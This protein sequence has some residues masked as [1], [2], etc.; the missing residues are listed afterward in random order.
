MADLTNIA[1]T[2]IPAPARLPALGAPELSVEY[3]AK[4]KEILEVLL[5]RRGASDWDRAVTFRDLPAASVATD[6]EAALR[7]STAYRSLVRKISD[8]EQMASYP[9]EIRAQLERALSDLARDR[10]ADI[11]TVENK[12]Q[13]ATL[14]MASRLQEI[15]AALDN[16]DAGVREFSAAYADSLRTVALRIEQLSASG[17]NGTA[18]L[19]ERLEAISDEVDG[20]QANY[21]LK[22]Q[23]NPVNGQ[24]P[25]I[26]GIDLSATSPVAG[27][28]TSALIF[29]AEAFKFLTQ[30]GSKQLVTISGDE[31]NLNANVT[32]RN[33]KVGAPD[34]LIQDPQFKDLIYW[35][36]VGCAVGDWAAYSG[37]TPWKGGASLYLG[38][39]TGAK[40]ESNTPYFNIEPGATYRLDFQISVPT[41]FNGS[42][43]V[44]LLLP[45]SYWWPMCGTVNRRGTWPSDGRGIDFG[46]AD[47]GQLLSFSTLL[48]VPNDSRNSRALIG[49]LDQYS[50]AQLEIGAMSITRVADASLV[51]DGVLSARHIVGDTLDVLAAYFGSVQLGV[52][53]ALWSGQSDYDTGVGLRLGT[54]GAGD[55]YLSMRSG[56]GK[57]VRFRPS[58]DTFE[59]SGQKL[60]SPNVEGLILETFSLSIPNG[61]LFGAGGTGERAYGSRSVVVSGS[62]QGTLTYQWSVAYSESLNGTRYSISLTGGTNGSSVGVTGNTFG[63]NDTLIA[64]IACLVTDGNGVSKSI[65]F[66]LNQSHGT[67]AS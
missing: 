41:G 36:R 30:N 27:P 51:G 8:A 24:P 16:N 20:L 23:T 61:G 32:A 62:Y 3:L 50:S 29:M 15:T 21:S 45:G 52:G 63:L 17:G 49:I 10:K 57:F 11:H 67:G 44:M 28:G 43:S 54:D 33:L 66:N 60:I 6:I 4:M 5:G 56:S 42:A 48:T 14:S 22:V 40:R 25:V 1:S 13:T 47:A 2:P 12:I 9:D 65:S 37:N 46:A 64:D 18:F 39:G 59:T 31:V 38:Q 19:E 7:N 34:N 58:T 35:G 55:P 53:G 26:A